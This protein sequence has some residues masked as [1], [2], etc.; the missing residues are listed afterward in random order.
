MLQVAVQ[1]CG[2]CNCRYDRGNAYTQICDATKDVATHCLAQEGIS[3]DVLLIVRGCTG[4]PYLYETINATHRI[5]CA[6]A[7]DVQNVIAQ[8]RMLGR[9]RQ[10]I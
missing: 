9:E 2:G 8:I 6:D 3:Y 1:F 5:I 10:H 4:C 7:Q